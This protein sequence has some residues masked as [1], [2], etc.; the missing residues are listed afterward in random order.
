MSCA[1]GHLLATLCA[2]LPFCTW[3]SGLLLAGPLESGVVSGSPGC[4][5]EQ[6]Y[7]LV[8]VHGFGGAASPG[9]LSPEIKHSK[10]RRLLNW[11]KRSKES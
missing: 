6:E 9:F 10:L 11:V 5:Q 4:F 3:V 8:A 1:N 7:C 2:Q